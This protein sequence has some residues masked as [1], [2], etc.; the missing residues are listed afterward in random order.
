MVS[1][2]PMDRSRPDLLTA[3]FATNQAWSSASEV[4][5]DFR[6]NYF[7]V[8]SFSQEIDGCTTLIY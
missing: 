5:A 8:F 6:V 1:R 7:S 3:A 4:A 2:T